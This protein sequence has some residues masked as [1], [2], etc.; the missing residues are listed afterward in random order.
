MLCGASGWSRLWSALTAGSRTR[1][2]EDWYRSYWTGA[3]RAYGDECLAALRAAAALCEARGTGFGVAMFPLLHRLD[4]YP[5]ADVH[6]AVATACRGAGVAFVDLLPAFEGQ[7]A[8]TLWVHPSDHHPNARA[9]ALAAE[10]LR[11][12]AAQLGR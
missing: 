2:T 12:F 11:A 1:A 7:D 3:Q 4:D 9:H 8:E 5:F 10:A 6:G